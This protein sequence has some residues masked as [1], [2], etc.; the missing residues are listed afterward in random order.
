MDSGKETVIL[1]HGIGRD[2]RMLS[3]LEARLRDAGYHV[4]N[5]SY[6]ST[7]YPVRELAERVYRR[8]QTACPEYA[9]QRVHFVTHSMGG[10]LARLIIETHRPPQLGRV[11][12][13]APPNHGSEVVDFMRRFKFYRRRFGPAG[14]QIGTD[15]HSI[16]HRL[17]PVDFEL[18]IIA[19]TRTRDRF[20]SWFILKGKN[21]GKV[22]VES[23][24]LAGMADHILIKGAHP[25]LPR[26][27]ETAHQVMYFLQ[28]GRFDG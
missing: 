18:G 8:I 13:I 26:L 24:K 23:T 15:A 12:M 19:G 2:K 6:L 25:I 10:I 11:V 1:L 20:F 14:L 7:H 3:V 4:Y 16:V 21:D 28:H 17:P 27:S 9:H 22:S 5:D